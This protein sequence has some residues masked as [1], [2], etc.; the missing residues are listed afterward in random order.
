MNSSEYLKQKDIVVNNVAKFIVKHNNTR[1]HLKYAVSFMFCQFLNII[2]L[3]LNYFIMEKFLSGNFSSLGYGWLRALGS[4]SMILS[5]VFP[6]MTMCQWREIGFGNA[7]VNTNYL[8]LLATNRI[9]EKI[10]VFYWFWLI[11]LIIITLLSFL[12]YC[13]M[14]CS[15]SIRWRDRF[16]AISINDTKVME[17]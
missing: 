5:D 9:T 3:F 11:T 8:C 6:R 4:R 7:V 2:N 14:F 13:T 17:I 16:L 1:S 15:K 12:Y 10:F